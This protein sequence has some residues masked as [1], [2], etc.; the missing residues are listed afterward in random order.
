MSERER[1][2]ERD[3]RKLEGKRERKKERGRQKESMCERERVLGHC[4]T[5]RNA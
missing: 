2:G 3:G 1:E 4:K 5:G